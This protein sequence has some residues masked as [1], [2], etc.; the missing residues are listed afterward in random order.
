VSPIV[1]RQSSVGAVG[2]SAV[3][4]IAVAAPAEQAVLW[5]RRAR[6]HRVPDSADTFREHSPGRSLAESAVPRIGIFRY[7]Y[8]LLL[9]HYQPNHPEPVARFA[10]VYIIA[11]IAEPGVS[12]RV[13]QPKSDR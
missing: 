2:G 8:K 13:A 11:T 6:N 7:T 12:R 9:W 3:V 5:S 10:P 1:R 4:K